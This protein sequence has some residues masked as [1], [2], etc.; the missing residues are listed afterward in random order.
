MLAVIAI[1]P[2]GTSQS[3]TFINV[4]FLYIRLLPCFY[5][6]IIDNQKN[7]C[8]LIVFFGS[9]KNKIFAAKLHHRCLTVLNTPLTPATFLPHLKYFP[10]T[11]HCQQLF[12]LI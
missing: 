7:V 6:G 10:I 12:C 9:V 1:K 5:S 2:S 8:K 4:V 3:Y 11:V